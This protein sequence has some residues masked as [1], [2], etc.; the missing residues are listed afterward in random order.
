V[1]QGEVLQGR[2]TV[3]GAENGEGPKQVEQQSNHR[4]EMVAGPGPT[5][6]PL[7]RR[8]G[9][10]RSTARWRKACPSWRWTSA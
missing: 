2:L 5:D 7:G 6:Q 4:A 3:A 1:A 9:L 8:M 10:W